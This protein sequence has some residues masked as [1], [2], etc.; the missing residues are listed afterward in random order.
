[1]ILE[2]NDY[3]HEDCDQRLPNNLSLNQHLAKEYCIENKKTY[4]KEVEIDSK[5]VEKSVNPPASHFCDN[6]AMSNNTRTR[7]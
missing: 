6:F 2:G 5:E 7:F 1:M 4:H 3:K